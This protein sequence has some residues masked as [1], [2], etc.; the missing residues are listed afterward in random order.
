MNAGMIRSNEA[1][2][3]LKWIEVDSLDKLLKQR[4]YRKGIYILWIYTELGQ[5]ALYVGQGIIHDRMRAR[6]KDEE[7]MDYNPSV[8]W[9]ETDERNEIEEY[10]SIKYKP[11][12]GER[13]PKGQPIRVNSPFTDNLFDN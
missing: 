9:A 12:F 10:L 13:W 7:I 8:F 5:T 11:V 1:G 3:K 4:I 2:K 6:V